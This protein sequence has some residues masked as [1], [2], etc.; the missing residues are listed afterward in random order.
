M[1]EQQR[2]I[3]ELLERYLG[4]LDA[5]TTLR[6]QL[7]A[8][9]AGIY[10][11]IARANFAAERGVRYGADHYDGRMRA[12]RRLE[13][14]RREDGV[15]V[16]AV[17]GGKQEEGEKQTQ[18]QAGEEKEEEQ[19]EEKKQAEKGEE[20]LK[21][22]P[23]GGDPLRWFGLLAPPALRSAQARAARA[24]GEVVPLLLSVSA[25]MEGLEIQVRRARKRRAKGA[26]AAEGQAA[27]AAAAAA[28]ADGRLESVS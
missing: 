18:T 26:L 3:D 6:Q 1:D 23:A 14:A 13:I 12:V 17:K 2:H 19:E 25:E 8:L 21:K 28:A 15:P 9:Q 27:A 22:R 11:D 10:Q 16:Y 20:E 7:S 5:Y 24:V 4:L